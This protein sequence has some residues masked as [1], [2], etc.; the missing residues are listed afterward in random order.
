[1]GVD[2]TVARTVVVFASTGVVDDVVVLSL[3]CVVVAVLTVVESPVDTIAG[4]PSVVVVCDR[5][6]NCFPDRADTP[7]AITTNEV[8]KFV[9]G[10]DTSIGDIVDI[11][12][13]KSAVVGASYTQQTTQNEGDC[14]K[15][16]CT[17]PDQHTRTLSCFTV[18]EGSH[19][20][21]T[22]DRTFASC[23]AARRSLNIATSR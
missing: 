14:D 22:S 7:S 20:S 8:T 16:F 6:R 19:C 5:S 2:S 11:T 10:F 18:Q 23:S 12:T 13:P 1:M 17:Q 4:G 21:D 15:Y 3:V 9:S